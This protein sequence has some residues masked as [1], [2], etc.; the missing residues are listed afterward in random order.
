MA[1]AWL[2]PSGSHSRSSVLWPGQANSSDSKEPTTGLIPLSP[3]RA[4]SWRVSGCTGYK[5]SE[6]RTTFL[7]A[8]IWVGVALGPYGKADI[9]FSGEFFGW[10]A[11]PAAFVLLT[12]GLTSMGRAALRNQ[13]FAPLSFVPLAVAVSGGLW[14][15]VLLVDS[16]EYRD[17]MRTSALVAHV[18]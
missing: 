11:I 3:D 18:A 16:G 17:V 8:N 5:I 4:S 9:Y 10:Y 2:L 13:T 15:L 12:L 14:F 6:I 7:I 1:T